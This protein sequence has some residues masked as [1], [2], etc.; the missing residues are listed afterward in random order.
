MQI[1]VQPDKNIVLDG[2]EQSFSDVWRQV[3]QEFGIS[4]VE[5]DVNARDVWER[6]ENC[7][8]FMWRFPASATITPKAKALMLAV[9][10]AQGKPTFPEMEHLWHIGDKAAGQKLMEAAGV[11][12]PKTW[13]FFEKESAL[14]FVE[15]AEYPVVFKLPGAAGKSVNVDL[16]H[17]RSEARHLV[18]VVFSCGVDELWRAK[19]KQARVVAG[20]LKYA[21]EQWK[22]KRPPNGPLIQGVCMFQEFIP[23]LDSDLRA[24]II[25]EKI[26]L[27]KRWNRPN[28]F[29][30]SGSGLVDHG[31]AEC[32][33]EVAEKVYSFAKKLKMN[34]VTM[35]IVFREGAPLVLELNHAYVAETSNNCSGYWVVRGGQAVW[36]DEKPEVERFTFEEFLRLKLLTE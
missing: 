7:S 11:P 1:A 6:L 9:A 28:D 27:Y 13:V 30:A 35:D 32:T 16:L 29:R 31:A 24:V 26:I 12:S 8:A 2:L 25:G 15:Q 4:I 10:Q 5:I 20:H 36:V 19:R 34:F 33:K 3:A 17:E 23:N 14:G 18:N 21:L 22:A